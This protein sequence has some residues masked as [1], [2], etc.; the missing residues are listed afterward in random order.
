MESYQSDHPFFPENTT[1]CG[2]GDASAAVRSICVNLDAAL[3]WPVV[4]Y[5]IFC[6]IYIVYAQSEQK[7]PG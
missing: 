1:K 4:W 3:D 5:I 2:A 6:G 7:G